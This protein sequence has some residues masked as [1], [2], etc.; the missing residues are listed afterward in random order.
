MRTPGWFLRFTFLIRLSACGSRR[1]ADHC[2][3][4]P[5]VTFVVWEAPDSST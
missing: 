1:L 5:S 3:E 2:C 4:R